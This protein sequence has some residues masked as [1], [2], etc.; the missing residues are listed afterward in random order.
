MFAE[1][2]AECGAAA[3]EI[4]PATGRATTP[5]WFSANGKCKRGIRCQFQ[6]CEPTVANKIPKGNELEHDSVGATI[7]VQ[8]LASVPER[9]YVFCAATSQAICKCQNDEAA[10]E[11]VRKHNPK[12]DSEGEVYGSIEDIKENRLIFLEQMFAIDVLNLGRR[13]DSCRY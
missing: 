9:N 10:G 1:G 4:G 5:C 12:E 11:Q 13:E 3:L 8:T 6:H 2:P 7:R